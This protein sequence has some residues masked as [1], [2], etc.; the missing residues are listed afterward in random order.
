MFCAAPIYTFGFSLG[1]GLKVL[2]FL[3]LML[4]ERN[5]SPPGFTYAAMIT[6]FVLVLIALILSSAVI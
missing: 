4:P 1:V 2:G 3:R 6:E 5:C